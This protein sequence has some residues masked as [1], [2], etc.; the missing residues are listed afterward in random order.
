MKLV[1]SSVSLFGLFSDKYRQFHHYGL[2]KK[3]AT[4]GVRS[5]TLKILESHIACVQYLRD[6]TKSGRESDTLLSDR[7]T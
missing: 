1:N 6:Y 2:F 7:A 5:A 4:Q 3:K